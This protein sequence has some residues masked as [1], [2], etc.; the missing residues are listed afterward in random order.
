MNARNGARSGPPVYRFKAQLARYTAAAKSGPWLLIDIPRTISKKLPPNGATTVEGTIND[1][2]FRAALERAESD[3]H[4]LRVNKAMRAGAGAKAGDSVRL[5][6]IVPEAEPA[7]PA[8]FKSALN[9]SSASK[10]FWKAISYMNRHDW[11]RW[12]DDA[13]RAE[14]RARRIA[15]AVEW[16]ATGKRQPCCF[17]TY[18]YA[19][20]RIHKNWTRD[21]WARVRCDL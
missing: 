10:T 5:A 4:R 21:D 17:N 18:E 14:T 1:H 8:D 11:V 2:P 7:L 12:I 15:L 13:K 3:G 20:R 19:L 6:V 16:L 9:A